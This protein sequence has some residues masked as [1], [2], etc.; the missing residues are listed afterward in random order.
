[1]C[2]KTENCYLKTFMKIRV[3]KKSALKCAKCYLK[4]KNGCLKAQT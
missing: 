1:M 2:L 4:T 3:R